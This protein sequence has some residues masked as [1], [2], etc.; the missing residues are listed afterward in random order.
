MD[1]TPKQRKFVNE[2][3]VDENATRAA[4]RAG[5]SQDTARQMGSENL[6]KPY[7]REAIAERMAEVAIAAS[8]TPEWVASQWAK[9]ARADPNELTQMR[10]VNCRHCHGV[11]HAYQWT[12]VEY[13]RAVEHAESL[14]KPAPDGLG[15]FGFDPAGE[16]NPDCPE[17]GGLGTDEVF[18]ADTRKLKGSAKLLFA[19]VQRTRD[20]VKV[21][22]R[23]QDAALNN[24]ARYLGMLVDR[25]ELSG[26]GGGPLPIATI[27]AE[28]LT[29]DQLAAIL[30]ADSATSG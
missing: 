24:L 5:Y 30:H 26:P 11:E 29:D 12:Q 9:L 6:S 4:I 20:G 27:K 15:G 22:M 2:Y 10:R 19:G 16:P 17:C 28:D 1:L 13:Y 14:N 25:K 7:I 3:C 23:D 8:V 21:L 18:F